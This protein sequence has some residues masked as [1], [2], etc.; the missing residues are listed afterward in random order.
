MKKI[1]PDGLMEFFEKEGFDLKKGD[2]KMPAAIK[3]HAIC[4]PDGSVRWLYPADSLKPLF[5]HF[6]NLNGNLLL[7]KALLVNLL[8]RFRIQS[9]IAHKVFS[10]VP[11]TR[12]TTSDWIASVDWAAF[13]GTRGTNR[14]M[15]FVKESEEGILSFIKIP[16]GPL[17]SAALS[18]EEKTLINLSFHSFKNVEFP[19]VLTAK[20]RIEISS[21]EKGR[22]G[23]ELT[24][25]HFDAVREW[26]GIYGSREIPDETSYRQQISKNIVS[27]LHAN[28]QRIPH[29]LTS[30]LVKLFSLARTDT[31]VYFTWSHGDF[32]PWN[33][34]LSGTGIG[35]YDLEQA[36]VRSAGYDLF[37]FVM[38]TGIL[39][40]RESYKTIHERIDELMRHPYWKEHGIDDPQYYYRSYLLG[41]VSYY[42]VR[43]GQ[44]P[45]W[46]V[47][48]DWLLN[49]WEQAI[50]RELASLTPGNHREKVMADLFEYVKNKTTALLKYT[51][52][53]I[54]DIPE[55]SDL[56]LVTDKKTIPILIHFIKQHPLVISATVLRKSYMK[57]VEVW[58]HDGSYLSLDLLHDF[59][60]KSLQFMKTE[61]ALSRVVAMSETK[62]TAILDD[63][64]YC[65]HFYQLN[66]AGISSK[67]RTY[68]E[69]LSASER[70]IIIYEV[71]TRYRVSLHDLEELFQPIPKLKAGII[72]FLRGQIVNSGFEGLIQKWNYLVDTVR[73]KFFRHGMIFTFSGVDGAGKS[74]VID[75]IKQT[76]EELYRKQV[77]VLRHRPSILPILS[78][79]KFGKQQA[80]E[81]ATTTPPR[82]GGNVNRISSILR[83]AYYFTDYFFGQCYIWM[84]YIIR[85]K[86]VIYD[87]YYFDF[88]LDAKRSNINLSSAVAKFFYPFITKPRL[89]F[90]LYATPEVIRQRKNEL[91]VQVIEEL[92]QSYLEEFHQREM[93]SNHSRYITIENINLDSTLQLIMDE[94]KH[95]V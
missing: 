92:N 52:Q 9:L 55:S 4:N 56:D 10:L 88:M 35:L 49:T 6:Y 37:H 66:G 22:R 70:A 57:T 72:R 81:R 44:E 53:S 23:D 12:G 14:K 25:Q 16:V 32:T 79:Y 24:S 65:L 73:D 38:Q 5:L 11:N 74:T 59:K 33:M 83:F 47:Q 94:Y 30:K 1:L 87:R 62:K 77:V 61:Q 36:E 15:V 58:M 51:W 89:N 34:Y 78:T 95:A 90:F 48:T 50:D 42:L 69:S 7:F 18:H 31:K 8:F 26:S 17:A 86:I 43:Y 75:Q 39:Q 2:D 21:V 45:E 85:G 40:K 76:L 91:P 3:L 41:Q 60:W 54:H 64:W 68:F 19:Q 63:L 71:E 93:S 27:I 82:Q 20:N 13:T 80:E 84:R 46:H 29:A 28:D 67:Y